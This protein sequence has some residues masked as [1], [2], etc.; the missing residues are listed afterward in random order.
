VIPVFASIENRAF[1]LPKFIAWPGPPCILFDLLKRNAN[2]PIN[3]SV[4]DLQR[5]CDNPKAEGCLVEPISKSILSYE[6]KL[7]DE[8]L[9]ASRKTKPHP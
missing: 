5:C 6:K 8:E 1:D 3:K 9:G 4:E 2:P 7:K